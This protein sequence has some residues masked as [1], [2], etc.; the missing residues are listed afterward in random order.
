[1]YKSGENGLV[2]PGSNNYG[3][4]GKDAMSQIKSEVRDELKRHQVQK[5]LRDGVPRRIILSECTPVELE[6]TNLINK[7]E[8]MGSGMQLTKCV[9]LLGEARD[10]YSDFIDSPIRINVTEEV[11]KNILQKF[12]VVVRRQVTMKEVRE[13]KSKTVYY[14]CKTTWWTDDPADLQLGG[15]VPL[16]VFGAPLFEAPKGDFL[17]KAVAAAQKYGVNGL[18]TFMAS[19]HKNFDT[20]LSGSPFTTFDLIDVVVSAIK[21]VNEKFSLIE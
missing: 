13:S 14:S 18:D 21:S 6:I 2:G 4:E 1:M 3:N 5:E 8:G 12:G 9:Q 19:H 11:Q 20:S 7:I 10:A 15:T 17:D 16:D